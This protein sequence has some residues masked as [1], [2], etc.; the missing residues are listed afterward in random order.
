VVER[1]ANHARYVCVQTYPTVLPPRVVLAGD[2]AVTFPY[3]P[4][5]LYYMCFELFKNALRATVEHQHLRHGR[6][7]PGPPYP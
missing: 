7:C 6:E 1:A 4:S 5:V 2:A 3:V